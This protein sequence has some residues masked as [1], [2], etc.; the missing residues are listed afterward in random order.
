MNTQ[1]KLAN[2]F[3]EVILDGTW[4][5]NTNFKN[6]LNGL[7]FKVANTKIQNL[8]TISI[9]SQHIHYYINGIKN[10]FLGGSLD[11]RDKYSFDF[12]EIDSR[13]KW[14][15][16]LNKFWADSEEFAELIA[17]MTEEKLNSNFVDE[18][19]GTYFR[20]IDAMIEHSYY[21]LGQIVLIKK[22]LKN[23]EVSSK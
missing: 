19:Y 10:V 8:N 3:R 11:I 4:I 13:E 23:A 14:E 1:S 15:F 12:P 17:S 18:K 22:M 2:R 21:H 7:D 5:A 20:N 16:F 6:E 9:L